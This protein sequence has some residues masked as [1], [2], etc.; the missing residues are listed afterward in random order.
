MKKLSGI[1]LSHK[2][3]TAAL[4]TIDLPLP[5]TLKIPM[6][7]NMGKPC[8]P[9]VSIGDTVSVG[10]KIGD[11]DAFLSVPVHSSV[12]GVVKEI[13][14]IKLASGGGCKAVTIET[15]GKQ[16]V[17]EYIAPPTVNSREEFIEAMK[18]S[19]I[20]G[21]GGAGFP[22]HI[23]SNPKNPIDMLI[24]NAAECEPYITSDHRQ[25]I[26]DCDS[27]IDGI[28]TV[29]KFADIK[30]TIIGIESN[31][32]DAISLLKDKTAAYPEISVNVLPSSYPQGAEKVL[33]YNTTG[34][35]IRE[36]QLP[37][38]AGTIVLNVSTVALIS[39]YMK[40][41]M[42]LIKRR[43]TVDGDIIK[44]PCNIFAPI[45]TP[46][47][48]I[49]SFAQC[50][51]EKMN[52]LLSGGP[53]MGICNFDVEFPVIKS[54][55]AILAFEKYTIPTITN[56]IRCGKCI[57]ACPI[58]LMPTEIEKAYNRRDIKSIK[59]LK[60]NLCMN[61]GSCTYVCP[62]GRKLAETNQLAKLLTSKT[63]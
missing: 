26:E 29:M 33:I 49:L 42:P 24:I 13:T 52:K 15:D 47:S 25:I 16:T 50:D 18:K 23:K 8:L 21:L 7:M 20:A 58:N 34:R 36:G 9:I 38:D 62:A 41:G 45:G 17:S 11:T 31:K 55:N 4:Q 10:Q 1:K 59:S 61:C 40:T 28:L 14:D 3:S 44:N 46:F 39:Q 51:I 48:E 54:T 53:M 6:L 63:N 32:P 27:V 19:G 56:C 37:S 2:K 30:S 60:N 12:S 57:K 22:T 5:K 35:I 43:I